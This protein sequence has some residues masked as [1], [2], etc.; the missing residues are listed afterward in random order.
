MLNEK[1]DQV[2]QPIVRLTD[3]IGVISDEFQPSLKII[4]SRVISKDVL[5][6]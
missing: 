5:S 2:A 4:D 3:L 1:V 6:I